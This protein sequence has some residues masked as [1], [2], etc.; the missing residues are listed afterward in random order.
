MTK[1]TGVF[2]VTRGWWMRRKQAERAIENCAAVW[3]DG[4]E[5][6]QIRDLKW[7]EAIAAR[8][9]QAKQCERLPSV[10]PNRCIFVP[11][12]SDPG[13]HARRRNHRLALNE[14]MKEHQTA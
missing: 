10:E 2:N 7:F 1:D 12:T 9:A 13:F 3:V 4:K 8:N 6:S 11:P 5:G 14:F